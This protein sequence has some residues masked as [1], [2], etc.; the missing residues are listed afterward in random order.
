M[1][2]E[3]LSA[4]DRRFQEFLQTVVDRNEEDSGTPMAPWEA[5][6]KSLSG[7]GARTGF[8]RRL[9]QGD[10]DT[11]WDEEVSYPQ[12]AP[13]NTTDESRPRT[14]EMG[15]DPTSQIVM[16]TFRDGTV[17]QYYNVPPDVFAEF[18]MDPS[19]GRFIREVLDAYPYGR[20]P[21]KF[22]EG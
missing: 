15:Y 1:A 14:L 12:I 6:A 9:F 7:T 18:S 19:P 5:A 10:Y 16:V 17:W 13:T 20:A 21:D 8:G 3:E 11:E 22:Q 2:D 4:A